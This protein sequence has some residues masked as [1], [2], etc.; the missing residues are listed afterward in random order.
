MGTAAAR[1]EVVTGKAVGS[2]ILVDDELLIG[3]HA[4]GVGRL[5]EDDE[6]SRMHAR[7]QLDATGFLSIEDLDSTNGTFV[8]GLRITAPQTLSQGD[9][10]EVGGST[11]VVRELDPAKPNTVVPPPR[12]QPVTPPADSVTPG[13]PVTPDE[14]GDP[15]PP[16]EGDGRTPSW[17]SIRVPGPPTPLSLKLEV[18]FVA[19]EARI[20]LDDASEAVHLVFEDGAWRAHQPQSDR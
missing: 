18:D 5:G 1:L 11:L 20:Q 15:A 19:G 7:L 9:T 2:S 14:P 8:N 12:V 10:I 17:S 3:R 4:D 6:I 13:E 16:A